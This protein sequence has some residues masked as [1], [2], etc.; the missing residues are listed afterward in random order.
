[1]TLR[2][3]PKNVLV[4]VVL[5][6]AFAVA[7]D[8]AVDFRRGAAVGVLALIAYLSLDAVLTFNPAQ[9]WRHRT[10]RR[11]QDPFVG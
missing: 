6:A 1:M 11:S 5:L 7:V 4:G 8:L 2:W 9:W 10:P 3:Y